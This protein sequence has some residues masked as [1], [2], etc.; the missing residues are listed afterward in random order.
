MITITHR[1]TP[2]LLA[3]EH[4]PHAGK[5]GAS[6]KGR[7]SSEGTQSAVRVLRLCNSRL[8]HVAFEPVPWGRK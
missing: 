7:A 4:R 5:G 3:V 6:K 1:V 2:P 8:A